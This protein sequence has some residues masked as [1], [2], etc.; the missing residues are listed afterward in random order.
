[1]IMGFWSGANRCSCCCCCCCCW[2]LVAPPG[3]EMD[4]MRYPPH[5]WLWWWF[6]RCPETGHKTTDCYLQSDSNK[7]PRHKSI[8]PFPLPTFALLLNPEISPNS[9]HL[10][11]IWRRRLRRIHQSIQQ[12]PTVPLGLGE[13]SIVRWNSN[14]PDFPT[15]FENFFL[16]F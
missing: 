6:R 3:S 10:G 8:T 5:P 7:I 15:F 2:P 11:F 13:I 1:M 4:E 9:W 12:I 16:I 14:F